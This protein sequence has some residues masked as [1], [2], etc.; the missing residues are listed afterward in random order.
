[1]AVDRDLIS[2]L[3]NITIHTYIC[4]SFRNT[5]FGARGYFTKITTA[6]KRCVRVPLLR[7]IN[8]PQ[9]ASTILSGG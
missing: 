1:M 6:E 4:G 5:T 2:N 3:K 9:S 8:E 7:N